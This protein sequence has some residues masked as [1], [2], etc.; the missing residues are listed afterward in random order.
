MFK[1]RFVFMLNLIEQKIKDGQ[2]LKS[3]TSQENKRRLL[4]SMENQQELQLQELKWRKL[5]NN[6]TTTKD[7]RCL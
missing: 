6:P 5:E 2:H 1:L 4:E 3:L 7:T